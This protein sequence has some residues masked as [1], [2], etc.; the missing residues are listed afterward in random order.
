M[1]KLRGR[2]ELWGFGENEAKIYEKTLISIARPL[3]R[4]NDGML[5]MIRMT[6][7]AL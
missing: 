4:I 3:A 2:Y 5:G 1:K 7:N 6:T